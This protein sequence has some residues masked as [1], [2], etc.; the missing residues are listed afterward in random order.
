MGQTA[1]LPSRC[2]LLRWPWPLVLQSVAAFRE[3]DLD[4]GLDLLQL[5]EVALG[6][7]AGEKSAEVAEMLTGRRGGRCVR[8]AGPRDSWGRRVN[9]LSLLVTLVTL[10]EAAEE[11]LQTRLET[12][13][14]LVDFEGEGSVGVE[15]LVR[16][17]DPTARK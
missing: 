3:G 7:L 13:F 17:S 1:S 10:S 4:F 12:A 16:V 8:P 9:G 14:G 5:E 6:Q 15:A 2:D 11:A